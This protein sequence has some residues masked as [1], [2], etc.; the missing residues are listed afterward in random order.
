MNT[1]PPT[2]QTHGEVYQVVVSVVLLV[3]VT[4]V[5]VVSCAITAYENAIKAVKIANFILK[6]TFKCL[7]IMILR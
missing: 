2:T 4:E 3:V 6:R 1:K 7:I 5:L